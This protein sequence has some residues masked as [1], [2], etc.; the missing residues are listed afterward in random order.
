MLNYNN[1][2]P[3]LIN[4]HSQ[5]GY[6]NTSTNYTHPLPSEPYHTYTTLMPPPLGWILICMIIHWGFLVTLAWWLPICMPNGIIH[7]HP[8]PIHPLLA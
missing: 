6:G 2:Y 3:H 4:F 1:Y 5:N 8:L 7:I